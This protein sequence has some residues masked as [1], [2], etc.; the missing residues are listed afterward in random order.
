MGGQHIQAVA[1]LIAPVVD[2]FATAA[3]PAAF[4]KISGVSPLITK[5]R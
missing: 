3:A 2:G 1:A 4:H 5:N